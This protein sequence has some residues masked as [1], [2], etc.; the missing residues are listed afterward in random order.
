MSIIIDGYNLLNAVGI[1]GRG[2]GASSLERSRTALLN[3]LAGVLDPAEIPRTT[4][5]FDAREAPPGL[6]RT[7]RHRGL[8]VRFAAKQ[9]D[10]DSVIEELIL[11]DHSPRRLTVVSSDHRLQRAA[12]RRKARAIDAD[13]WFIETV[14][15]HRQHQESPPSAGARPPVPLLQ[16]QVEYW[17]RQFGGL[18]SLS[19]VEAE[20]PDDGPVGQKPGE[21]PGPADNPA[22]PVVPPPRS[23]STPVKSE[24]PYAM[25]NPFP[26]GYGEDL[27]RDE[28]LE[29]P[30][31][32][33][34]PGYAEDL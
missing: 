14:R 27:L 2:T 17:L 18:D 15:L 19:R 32:P 25:D 22:P 3:F 8:A 34:P 11:A 21:K 7:V 29:D 10:A 9:E 30:H 16:E 6:P 5:V 26:P 23:P 28:T 33:F 31:S 4:I 12:K 1:T 24:K 13:V 20:Q